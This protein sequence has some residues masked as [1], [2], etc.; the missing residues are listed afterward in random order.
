MLFSILIA[1]LTLLAVIAVV[2]LILWMFKTAIREAISP[3]HARV[4]SLE[5][6][7]RL[8][9]DMAMERAFEKLHHSDQPAFDKLLEDFKAHRMTEQQLTQFIERLGILIEDSQHRDR[10]PAAN[11]LLESALLERDA[12]HGFGDFPDTQMMRDE[13]LTAGEVMAKEAGDR[14]TGQ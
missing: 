10:I 1:A 4:I 3:T 14:K 2:K 13:N 6:H 5:R 7:E 8:I 9:W 12:R 11:L